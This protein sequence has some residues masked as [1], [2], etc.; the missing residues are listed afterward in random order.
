[1]QTV[2]NW[3]ATLGKL[4]IAGVLVG[5]LA[6]CFENDTQRGVAGAVA[7]GA[8]AGATGN[9]VAT[10]ALIGGAAGV[11]CRDTGAQACQNTRN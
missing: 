5:S 4:A 8:V 11:F 2:R 10:G 7:G 1:M 3:P 6:G 9:N